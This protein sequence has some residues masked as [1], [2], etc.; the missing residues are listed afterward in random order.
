G[1]LDTA[2]ARQLQD[3]QRLL[4]EAMT[5]EMLEAMN[6]LES[7]AQQLDGART[8]QSLSDLAKQQEQLREGLEKSAEMLRRAALEGSMQ[9]LA[10]EARDLAQRQQEFTDSA[11]KSA[12]EKG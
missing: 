7:S 12:A 8:R 4:R 1:A 2:L 9:I 6:Q 5:P 10:D 11:A 3:A